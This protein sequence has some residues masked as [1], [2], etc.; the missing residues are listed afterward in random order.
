MA[1][2]RFEDTERAH[3]AVPKRPLRWYGRASVAR[4]ENGEQAIM[5]GGQCGRR[6]E[7]E[8]QP[9]V[10]RV[11][12]RGVARSLTR[13]TNERKLNRCSSRSGPSFTRSLSGPVTMI[14]VSG[15]VGGA[16]VEWTVVILV[17]P[18]ARCVVLGRRCPTPGAISTRRTGGGRT[19]RYLLP[20][21]STR[22]STQ[23]VPVNHSPPPSASRAALPPRSC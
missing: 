17:G 9:I 8:I 22:C 14:Q 15:L 16:V 19:Q 1:G 7:R 11:Y 6:V 4:S 18:S 3:A 23:K 5:G 10:A 13:E 12:R 20:S 21:T 2:C